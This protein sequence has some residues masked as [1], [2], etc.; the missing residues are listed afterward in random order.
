MHPDQ[1]HRAAF[2]VGFGERIGTL[3]GRGCWFAMADHI[4][5]ARRY[6]V[7]SRGN[8]WEVVADCHHLG[9]YPSQGEALQQAVEWAHEDGTGGCT[10]QVLLETNS[11][12]FSPV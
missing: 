9:R 8:A 1:V 12:D 11:K 2:K 7:V 10:A 5:S 3:N 4:A 6:Y